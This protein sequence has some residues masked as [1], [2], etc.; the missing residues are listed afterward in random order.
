MAGVSM[1]TTDSDWIVTEAIHIT[2]APE[3]SSVAVLFF[4]SVKC[5]DHDAS[6]VL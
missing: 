1:K 5:H 6:A 3:Q 2:A 4:S